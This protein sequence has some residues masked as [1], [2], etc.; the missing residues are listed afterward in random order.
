MFRWRHERRGTS[1]SPHSFIV[2]YC[3][4]IYSWIPSLVSASASPSTA[5]FLPPTTMPASNILLRV[6]EIA[7]ASGVPYLQNVAKVA[8]VFFKQ[9]EGKGKNKKDAKELSESIGNTIVVIDT[10][11]C[12]HGKVGAPYFEGICGEMENYLAGI[13]QDLKDDQRKHRGIKGILNVDDFKDA[14]QTYRKRVD[15]LKMDFLIHLMGDCFLEVIQVHS[16]VQGLK[17]GSEMRQTDV[18]EMTS[19]EFMIRM[20]RI[21]KHA[22]FFFSLIE[23]P[24]K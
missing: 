17:E 14:I 23:Y 19:R 15:D 5:H 3:S 21:T 24:R 6:S 8:V 7:E 12:M 16:I 10:L 20:I 4:R 11:I 13:A 2:A 22:V 9:L 18:V 1:A